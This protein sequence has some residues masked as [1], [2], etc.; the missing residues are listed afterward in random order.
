MQYWLFYHNG[1]C[2]GGTTNPQVAK[3][4]TLYDVKEVT[5]QVY[6]QAIANIRN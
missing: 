5:K 2:K 6:T 4:N 3:S 1:V